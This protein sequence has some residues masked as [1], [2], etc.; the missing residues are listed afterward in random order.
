MSRRRVAAEML[1]LRVGFG[2]AVGG[3]SGC[4]KKVGEMNDGLIKMRV[5]GQTGVSKSHKLFPFFF[6]FSGREG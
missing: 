5:E 2:A 4:V 3:R 1:D 6:F